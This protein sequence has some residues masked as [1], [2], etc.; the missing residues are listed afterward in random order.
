MRR[1]WRVRENI[2]VMIGENADHPY[3]I[4]TDDELHRDEWDVCKLMGTYTKVGPG[5]AITNI[6][7]PDELVEEYEEDRRWVF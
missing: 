5:L 1:A 2:T 4:F 3:P 6:E 7:L